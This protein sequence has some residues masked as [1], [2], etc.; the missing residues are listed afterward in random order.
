MGKEERRKTPRRN[1]LWIIWRHIAQLNYILP[2]AQRI[3]RRCGRLH[4]LLVSKSILMLGYFDAAYFP[5]S[6][7]G[8]R[9]WRYVRVR[10]A[11]VGE[12]RAALVRTGFGLD[13]R[14]CWRRL[15][16]RSFGNS[17]PSWRFEVVL[18]FSCS[19]NYFATSFV[20]RSGNRLA[21]ALAHLSLNHL[22]VL[23]ELTLPPDLP[24]II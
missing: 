3:P 6:S 19:F 24:S 17:E 4:Y 9:C 15:L 14:D 20:K 22:D 21:H 8:A 23:E 5:D 10:P 12:A 7:G 18:H 13:R 1:G 2:G 11:V 16:P